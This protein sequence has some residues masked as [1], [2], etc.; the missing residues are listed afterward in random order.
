M[1]PLSFSFLND[2]TN[3]A[4]KAYRRYIKRDLPRQPETAAQREGNTTHKLLE[5]YI[6][7]AL[8]GAP[9]LPV[10]L[11]PFALPFKQLKAKAEL[12]LGMTEDF[13]PAPFNGWGACGTWFRGKLDAVV[14]EPPVAFLVDWKTSKVR[15]DDTELR[16]QALLLLANY[17]EVNRISGSYVWLKEGRMGKV[18]DDLAD[19]DRTYH[20]IKAAIREAEDYELLGEWPCKPNALCS[21][22]PVHDCRFNSNP[23]LVLVAKAG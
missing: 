13:Q 15:E 21:W 7:G 10:S 20:S 14:I 3:C 1:I 5:A 4:H 16:C 8:D 22:C 9:R 11:E 6:N 19:V 12:K 2:F 23:S 17:P 18:Y